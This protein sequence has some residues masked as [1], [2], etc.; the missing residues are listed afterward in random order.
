MNSF[1]TYLRNFLLETL[2]PFH[3]R[4][5]WLSTPQAYTILAQSAH[6]TPWAHRLVPCLAPLPY[7]HT[8][9]SNAIHA[10]KYRGNTHAVELLGT[11]LA[12]YVSE[13]LA[14][15]HMFGAFTHT[16][17]IPIPL[18]PDKLRKRGFNQA[19]RLTQALVRELGDS[20]VTCDTSL[21]VRQM[22]TPSQTRQAHKT[23][24]IENIRGAFHVPTPAL[25][26]ERDILLLDDVITTGATLSE[27]QSTLLRAGARNV[28]CVTVA[29]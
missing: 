17:C 12:P 11:I 4:D 5:R 2:F 13:E 18:H 21:L 8:R 26:H 3:P 9:V 23:D 20:S 1:Y 25:V 15:R 10:M 24:R 29:Q 16:I 27:A 7:A 6:A 19:E 14:D 28:L 22:A